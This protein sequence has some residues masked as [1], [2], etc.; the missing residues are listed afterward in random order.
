MVAASR[1][2]SVSALPRV[3]AL[4]T[5]LLVLKVAASVVIEY[6]RYFPPDFNSD[7]LQGRQSYFWGP[8]RWAFY[9]HVVSG[10]LT[11]LVGTIL[12]SDRFRARFPA[13]HRRLGRVQVA[14]ILLLLTPS[15][16]WMAPYAETGAV[17]ATGLGLLAFATAACVTMG[18]RAAVSRRLADHQRWML[19][20]YLLLC[21]AVVIRL[22]G[23]LASVVQ[24]DANW[25]YPL[26]VWSSWLMP[27]LIFESTLLLRARWHPQPA[28]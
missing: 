13:W 7:F 23:G 21:S 11:L 6:R 22:I 3:L 15:G 9:T 14:S 1:H 19:R 27:L 2:S 18:W 25:L 8:Y 5:A 10:P 26:A 20:T 28:A 12:I 17:A 4:V 16:L 24:F